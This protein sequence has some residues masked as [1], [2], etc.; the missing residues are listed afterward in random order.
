MFTAYK[1]P[2][3]LL[4]V[5]HPRQFMPVMIMRKVLL[6]LIWPRF[7]AFCA[8]GSKLRLVMSA[9]FSG[10]V[11]ETQKA[12]ECCQNNYQQAHFS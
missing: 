7:M 4:N 3:E 12:G 5:L 11:E 8:Q 2:R 1:M 6:H 10:T 9:L